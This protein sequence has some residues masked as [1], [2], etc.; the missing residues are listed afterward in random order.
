MKRHWGRREEVTV[1]MLVLVKDISLSKKTTTAVAAAAAAAN[2]DQGL[3]ER[4][5]QQAPL[6]WR[7]AFI[8]PKEH[9]HEHPATHR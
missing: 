5:V 2:E 1:L 9:Q 7:T 3:V 8:H 4:E 6:G